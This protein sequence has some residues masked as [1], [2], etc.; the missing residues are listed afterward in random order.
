VETRR[1]SAL[2]ETR[3][4]LD[5]VDT[6]CHLDARQLT[7]STREVLDHAAEA[8]VTRVVTIGTSLESSQRAVELA[9][10]WPGLF[11]TVGVDPNECAHFAADDLAELRRLAQTPDVVAIGEIGL[12]YYWDKVPRRDQRAVFETQLELADELSLPV[13]IHSREASDDTEAILRS[14]SS[15]RNHG[16]APAGVMH[17]FS[18]TTDMA[19]R[20]IEAGFLISFAGNVTYKNAIELQRAA[21]A[22]P[23]EAIVFE[24]DAPYLAPVP[25]RGTRNEPAF[26]VEVAE[27]VAG[28]RDMPVADVASA[29][30]RNATR[31]FGWQP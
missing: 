31:L 19:E 10:E 5:L 4:H 24:T 7:E 14:W 13:V 27:F 16:G 3:R 6:H 26:V 23:L 1:Q 15:A 21:Q 28:L 20:L 9:S 30:T 25:Y 22:L 11:A 12:D 29:T 2:A 17:C 18:G 8:G